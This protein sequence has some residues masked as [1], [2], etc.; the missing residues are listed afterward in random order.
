MD[1]RIKSLCKRARKADKDAACELLRIHYTDVY[2]YLRRLC[3]SQADA[4]DLTQQTFLK[5]WSSLDSF[6]GRSKFSTWLYRIAHNTYIDS[7]RGNAGSNRDRSDQWW[8]ECI[9]K[10]PGPFANVA[11]RL[12]ARRLYETVDKLDEDKR[13]IVHLHYY[14]GFS[15]RETSKVLGIASSTVKY[16]LREVLRIL[17]V[18]VGVEEN[19]LN[20][21]QTISIAKGEPI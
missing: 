19:E 15:I 16:R 4:E 14:Q 17:R 6:A 21:E 5:V 18:K 8:A 3:G 13:D 12:L 2:S 1:S 11:E 7:K 20:L 10:N 9:D